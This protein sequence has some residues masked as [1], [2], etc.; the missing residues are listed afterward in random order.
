MSWW[1]PLWLLPRFLPG[2]CASFPDFCR[3]FLEFKRLIPLCDESLLVLQRQHV[4]GGEKQT[5]T[6]Q[7][8]LLAFMGKNG[9]WFMTTIYEIVMIWFHYPIIIIKSFFLSSSI[10][11]SHVMI[12]IIIIM[13]SSHESSMRKKTGSYWVLVRIRCIDIWLRGT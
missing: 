3:T 10:P 5:S 2:F 9:W 1:K 7:K 8:Y 4:H 12:S 11:S 6:R 13:A